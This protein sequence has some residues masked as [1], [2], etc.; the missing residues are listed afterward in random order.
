MLKISCHKLLGG[1]PVAGNLIKITS[2]ANYSSD[3]SSGGLVDRLLYNWMPSRLLK[4]KWSKMICIEGN[5]GVGKAAF[6]EA[7]SQRFELKYFPCADENYDLK[8]R[9]DVFNFITDEQLQ[10]ELKPDSLAQRSMKGSIDYFCQTPDDWE[11]TTYLRYHML[12]NRNY[13]YSDALVHLLHTGQ[14]AAVVRH[15]YSD[16]VFAEAQKA[17]KWFVNKPEMRDQ[18]GMAV[19]F[20]EKK[21]F[22]INQ[23]LLPPQVILYLNMPAEEAYEKVQ[24]NG[25]EYEKQLPLEYFH[26]IEDAYID[27][28][29]AAQ[30]NGVNV[31]DLNVSRMSTEDLLNDLDEVEELEVP[32][33][34]W[35]PTLTFDRNLRHIKRF[36]MDYN[37]RQM[38]N[39]N[40]YSPVECTWAPKWATSQL[41]TEAEY[42]G[43]HEKGFHPTKDLCHLVKS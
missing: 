24:Q 5:I 29:A 26:R 18:S 41:A 36:C 10:W 20:Y 33:S 27:N 14:G 35:Q 37:E 22:H 11:H 31:I 30:K 17:M 25:N 23:F 42:H 38:L 3:A 6:A 19:K 13:Q 40:I 16:K 12:S 21:A 2:V 32:F 43:F 4:E 15:F 34:K 9:R 8:R 1:S 7:L 28:L 39:N